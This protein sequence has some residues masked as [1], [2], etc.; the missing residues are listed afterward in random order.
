S[1]MLEKSATLEKRLRASGVFDPAIYL[2]LNPDVQDDPWKHFLTRGLKERRPF[3]TPTLVARLFAQLDSDI[4]A[5]RERFRNAAERLYVGP[6]NA[7]I[8]RRFRAKGIRIGV[9]CSSLGN[10]FMREIADML[11][12]G[13]RAEGIE[14]LQRDE[15][16]NPEE[17]F[18]LRVFVAPHE[19]FW[20]VQGQLWVRLAS[21]VNSVLYI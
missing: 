7:A 11:A 13:L 1:A 16:G 17:P 6:G 5:E 3:T 8:A 9:F 21:A 2:S 4:E 19:F 18:D 15:T 20:L 12:W 10:F 14:T